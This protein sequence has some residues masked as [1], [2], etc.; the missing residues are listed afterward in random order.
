MATYTNTNFFSGQTLYG[1]DKAGNTIKHT[2]NIKKTYPSPK[3][4]PGLWNDDYYVKDGIKL[5]KQAWW[6]EIAEE[7]G[8][9]KET[10]GKVFIDRATVEEQASHLIPAAVEAGRNAFRLFVPD[11]RVTISSLTKDGKITGAVIHVK[12]SEYTLPV[13]YNGPIHILNDKY[14]RIATFEATSGIFEGKLSKATEKEIRATISV[15]GIA[16]VSEAKMVDPEV[17]KLSGGGMFLEGIFVKKIYGK[18]GDLK[19]ETSSFIG[20]FGGYFNDESLSGGNG[21]VS[22]RLLHEPNTTFTLT[23]DPNTFQLL[24]FSAHE[25]V[26]KA[27]G[28]ISDVDIEISSL[29]LENFKRIESENYITYSWLLSGVDVTKY[30]NEANRHWTDSS[31]PYDL[32]ESWINNMQVAARNKLSISVEFKKGI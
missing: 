26:Q 11:I 12:D 24:G 30:V 1:T 8:L 2:N 19:Q 21:K 13:K 16:F 27:N 18:K 32:Y 28:D 20:S 6:T 4:L 5:C 22:G 17:L 15:G 7:S 10:G 23:Y 25:K 29:P 14:D 3:I 31:A 9:L